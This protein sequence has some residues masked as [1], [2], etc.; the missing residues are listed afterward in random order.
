LATADAVE[1]CPDAV[2][3]ERVSEILSRDT[4]AA[5]TTDFVQSIAVPSV[6]SEARKI[7]RV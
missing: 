2:R 1:D 6:F 7:G 5:I 3:V 4:A